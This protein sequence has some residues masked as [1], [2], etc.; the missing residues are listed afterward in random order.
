MSKHAF[1]GTDESL[2]Q[3]NLTFAEEL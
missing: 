2:K 3:E 1:F